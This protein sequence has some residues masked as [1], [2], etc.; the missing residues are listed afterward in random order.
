MR[1]LFIKY[2]NTFYFESLVLPAF[3]NVLCAKVE[4]EF[5]GL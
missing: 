2:L 5:L 1:A 3:N 4:S